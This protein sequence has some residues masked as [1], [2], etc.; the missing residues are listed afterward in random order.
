M[1]DSGKTD[2][3]GIFDNT[4]NGKLATN[5]KKYVKQADDFYDIIEGTE[6]QKNVTWGDIVT[7]IAW[8]KTNNQG[9]WASNN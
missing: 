5:A 9:P 4:P 7:Y 8:A 3:T 6:A 2:D 1:E